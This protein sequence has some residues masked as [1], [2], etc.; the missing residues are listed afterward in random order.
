VLERAVALAASIAVNPPEGVEAVK[1][2]VNA[3]I[4]QSL[5]AGWRAEF[6]V[7]AESMAAAQASGAAIFPEKSSRSASG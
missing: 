2:L 6:A 7:M 3:G 4:G 1:A 5:E